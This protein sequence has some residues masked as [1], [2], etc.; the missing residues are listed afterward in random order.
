VLLK[1][2]TQFSNRGSLPTSH[3]LS[4][5]GHGPLAAQEASS[6]PG[7]D[8]GY[9]HTDVPER[10]PTDGSGGVPHS[11]EA[12]RRANGAG[13]DVAG[14]AGSALNDGLGSSTVDRPAARGL[15]VP[16]LVFTFTSILYTQGSDLRVGR[17]LPCGMILL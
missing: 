12:K 3:W 1:P 15:Q 2:T 13:V 6:R 10:A 8:G 11:I 16:T 9:A 7:M 5:N 17:T 14:S 4:G